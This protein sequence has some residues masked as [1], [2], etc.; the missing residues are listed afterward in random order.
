MRKSPLFNTT[1]LDQEG[2]RAM[3]NS[4]DQHAKGSASNRRV[5]PRLEYRP[6]DIAI[7]VEHPAG[8]VSRFLVSPRNLSTG[9]IAFL[10][11]G[12]LHTGSLCRLVLIKR[13]GQVQIVVGKIA[14]CRHVDGQVHEVGVRFDQDIDLKQ[15]VC[16]PH[17]QPNQHATSIEL[18]SLRGR[19]VHIAHHESDCKLIAHHLKAT[20]IQ[21]STVHTLDESLEHIAKF[22]DIV[23]C[24][25]DMTEP[26]AAETI[27][28]VRSKGFA[29]PIVIVSAESNGPALEQAKNAAGN[30]SEI[31]FKPYKPAGL[32]ELM[33]SL[34]Q[35][36]GAWLDLAQVQSTFKQPGDLRELIDE[37][38]NEAHKDAMLLLE[39]M[40]SENVPAAREICV[41]LKGSAGG[42]GFESISQCA[43]GCLSE[44]DSQGLRIAMPFLRTLSLMCEY[45]AGTASS[46][47]AEP[48]GAAN[49]SDIHKAA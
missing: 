45:V 22:V 5:Q 12:F 4:L 27:A 1:R 32:F 33:T 7:S 3:L 2:L 11:G 29:G 38:V 16:D 23:L 15:F 40:R 26:S 25:L 14:S 13:D 37:F 36:S 42:V 41:R 10:H 35:K 18:P 17:S 49:A 9:G 8:G 28:M 43:A 6:S 48:H 30:Q 44:L 47:K 21:L 20:G 39:A 31:L 24:D 34:H 46:A 19:V